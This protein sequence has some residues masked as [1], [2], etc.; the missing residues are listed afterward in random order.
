MI[1]RLP[2]SA[3]AAFGKYRLLAKLGQGGMADVYLATLQASLGFEKL[4]V[5]KRLKAAVAADPDGVTMFLDEARIAARLNHPN[6][7]QTYELGSTDEEPYL[8]MEYLEGQPLDRIVQR[9]G[10]EQHLPLYLAILSDAL[11][12][13]HHAHELCDFDGRPLEVVHRDVSPHNI[14]VTYEG[15]VKVVDFGIAKWQTRTA[16]ATSTGVVKGKVSYMAPEQALCAP[17]DRRADLFAAGVILSE[18]GACGRFWGPLSDMQIL[19]RM[20]V[21]DLPRL[22]ERRPDVPEPLI[23]ISERALAL[24]PAQRQAT[25]AEM[26]DAIEALLGSLGRRPTPA[27]MGQLISDAFADRRAEARALIGEQLGRAREREADT[28][29]ALPMLDDRAGPASGR[30]RSASQRRE[31]PQTSLISVSPA[32]APDP[33]PPSADTSAATSPVASSAA[34]T[35]VASAPARAFWFG[36]GG[37]AAAVLLGGIAVG[38]VLAGAMQS[39]RSSSSSLA[40]PGSNPSVAVPGHTSDL[41]P[42]LVELRID[43]TPASASI[44]LDGVPVPANPFVARFPRDR[45]GHRIQ[46][47]A[48]GHAPAA[49]LVVFDRDIAVSLTLHPATSPGAASSSAPLPT[50]PASSSTRDPRPP[51]PPNQP[52]SHTPSGVSPA[53]SSSQPQAGPKVDATDPWSTSQKPR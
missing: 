22:R 45:T 6:L 24:D 14:L 41:S 18:F 52:S 39:L 23:A 12:G 43:V 8:T 38:A 36:R 25:A 47:T 40:A 53:P 1:V 42:A 34:P 19:Q 9:L 46:A 48:E 15:Q 30:A 21:G 29:E 4:V 37:A 32:P 28:A 49:Q 44:L 11:A 35:A 13:L 3:A 51:L 26:R 33:D 31:P 20:A 27:E 2:A 50:T 7:V 17:V 10:Y 16:E 5:I